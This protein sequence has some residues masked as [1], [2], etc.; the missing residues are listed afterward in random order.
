[1]KRTKYDQHGRSKTGAAKPESGPWL[2]GLASLRRGE[3]TRRGR[4]Y[5]K[6]LARIRDERH[7]GMPTLLGAKLGPNKKFTQ[8]LAMAQEGVVSECGRIVATTWLAQ[9]APAA[10]AAASGSI[11]GPISP[12]APSAVPTPPRA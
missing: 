10:A 9:T 2:Q 8:A 12:S 1:M 11:S 5:G 4:R 7:L 6:H 3:L